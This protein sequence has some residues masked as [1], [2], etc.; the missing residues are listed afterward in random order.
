MGHFLTGLCYYTKLNRVESVSLQESWFSM[1]VNLFIP[2]WIQLSWFL[3]E[4]IGF[5]FGFIHY[6]CTLFN[7]TF[8]ISEISSIFWKAIH[9]F[10]SLAFL[11]GGKLGTISFVFPYW[12][13]WKKIKMGRGRMMKASENLWSLKEKVVLIWRGSKNYFFRL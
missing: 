1:W 3:S 4:K 8:L 5:V 11:G 6:S 9:C 2:S 7:P 13:W 12:F 10:S